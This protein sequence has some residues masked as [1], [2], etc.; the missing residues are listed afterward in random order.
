MGE[1]ALASGQGLGCPA[2]PYLACPSYL[3]PAS[4]EATRS[5]PTAIIC[6]TSSALSVQWEGVRLRPV[7]SAGRLDAQPGQYATSS[8]NSAS[9]SLKSSS[10]L[11]MRCAREPNARAKL[12]VAHASRQLS[13]GLY[14]LLF[15]MAASGGETKSAGAGPAASAAC[16]A[17]PSMDGAAEVAAEVAAEGAVGSVVA[18]LAGEE[19]DS[20]AAADEGDAM[21]GSARKDRR[22]TRPSTNTLKACNQ[23]ER[24]DRTIDLANLQVNQMYI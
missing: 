24:A 3:L 17:L 15:R 2:T 20:A 4:R 13:E 14:R 7:C 12:A 18:V 22:D 9:P 8:E 1:S 11:V 6:T 10:K 21:P 19:A 23:G 5:A 16:A